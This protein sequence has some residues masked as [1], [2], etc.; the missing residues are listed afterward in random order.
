MVL[1]TPHKKGK[2]ETEGKKRGGEP[3]RTED[4]SRR[5][6]RNDELVANVMR[7]TDVIIQLENAIII[8]IVG[9]IL[10]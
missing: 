10:Q 9:S 8:V 7:L 6:M 3:L 5:R 1:R 2:G 4:I